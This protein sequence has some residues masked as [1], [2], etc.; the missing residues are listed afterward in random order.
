MTLLNQHLYSI[1][2]RTLLLFTVIALL[3]LCF[4]FSA[5]SVSAKTRLSNAETPKDIIKNHYAPG[6]CLDADLNTISS[7]GTKVQL[8]D[9]NSSVQQT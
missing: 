7:N 2:R 4:A 9:S 3:V 6:R 5:G 1:I 8:W